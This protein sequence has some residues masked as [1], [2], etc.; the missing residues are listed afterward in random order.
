M[1]VRVGVSGWSYPH[2]RGDFYPRGLRHSAELS[3][4]AGQVRALE[5]N[6]SFYRLQRPTTYTRWAEQTPSTFRFAVKGSRFISHVRSLRDVRVPLANFLASGPLVLGERLGPMLWQLPATLEYHEDLMSAFLSLLP[7]T[8]TEATALARE[9]DARLVD[10]TGCARLDA[11]RPLRHAI[12]PR[13]PS[14]GSPA[15]VSALARHQVAL[16]VAD[17]AGEFP[18]FDQVTTDL[19]YVR[20]HGP[21]QLYRGGYDGEQLQRWADRVRRWHETTGEA[22][23][24]FDNDAHGRAP[25]DAVTLNTLLTDLLPRE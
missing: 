5:V 23:V 9:H 8:T 17:S 24:F 12:E 11:D 7:R 10:E 2:W 18:I 19:T 3:Y 21:E 16:V 4:V 1:A 22:W 20:L 6:A 13:H 15:A 25:H 14:F